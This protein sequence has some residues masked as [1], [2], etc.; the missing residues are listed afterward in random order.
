MQLPC[1][2][3]AP[4]GFLP[5]NEDVFIFS[6]AGGTIYFLYCF[7]LM[8]INLQ[9]FLLKKCKPMLASDFGSLIF[10]SS[11]IPLEHGVP[12]FSAHSYSY[13]VILI[14]PCSEKMFLGS[15]QC[16][17]PPLASPAGEH[18]V[19]SREMII[20]AAVTVTNIS[21]IL[22]LCQRFKKRFYLF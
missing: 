7:S 17:P 11:R 1:R 8:D 19:R 15:Q 18:G 3:L 13:P 10:S 6:N 5:K 14:I 16:V 12:H 4:S 20:I 22:T 2:C 9:S 21:R